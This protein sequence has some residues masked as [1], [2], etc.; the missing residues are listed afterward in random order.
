MLLV[1]FL[2]SPS[3]PRPTL[4]SFWRDVTL[5]PLIPSWADQAAWSKVQKKWL[6]QPAHPRPSPI[7]ICE[8]CMSR[9]GRAV[10]T[11]VTRHWFSSV[12]ILLGVEWNGSRKCLGDK[13]M[14]WHSRWRHYKRLSVLPLPPPQLLH[15]LIPQTRTHSSNSA[16]WDIL[17]PH[18]SL[19]PG[20]SD[21]EWKL[22]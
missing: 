4:T 3:L 14:L 1:T 17:I 7:S 21:N 19:L 10:I 15:G 20:L 6:S 16:F 18:I 13:P 5:E 11:A 9:E 12:L 2:P 8:V 22:S